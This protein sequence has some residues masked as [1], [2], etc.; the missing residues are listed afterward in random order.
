M[1]V[2]V[3]Y[4]ET[5]SREAQVEVDDDEFMLWANDGDA[6]SYATPEQAIAAEPGLLK[7][8]LKDQPDYV[9]QQ[10]NDPSCMGYDHELLEADL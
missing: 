6:H 8:F 10:A 3:K 4:Q 7:E 2:K 9:W 1:I 5:V